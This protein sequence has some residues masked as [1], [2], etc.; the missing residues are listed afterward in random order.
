PAGRR[1]RAPD[2]RDRHRDDAARRARLLRAVQAAEA[3]D[4]ALAVVGSHASGAADPLADRDQ[5]HARLRGAG[6]RERRPLHAMTAPLFESN[7]TSLER[8]HRGKVR[9]IYALGDKHMLIVTSDRL[10]AFDVVLP[11]PIPGKGAVLTALTS[12]WM[13]KFSSLLPN[14]NAPE[15]RLADH[16]KP[17]ELKQCEGRA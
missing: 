11:R 13:Q 14:Q 8:I 17:D 9:D 15:V 16:L 12:F 6:D 2:A 1:L 3:T 4:R 7:L 10:S 5:P